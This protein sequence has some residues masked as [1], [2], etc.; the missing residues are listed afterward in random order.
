MLS[1]CCPL[2]S[3]DFTFGGEYHLEEELAI[4]SCGSLVL[5][6]KKQKL[7]NIE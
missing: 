1:P 2:N 5:Y 3:M 6:F 4:S 7:A